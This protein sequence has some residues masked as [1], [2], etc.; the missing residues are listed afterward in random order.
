MRKAPQRRAKQGW[1]P[2]VGWM[3]EQRGGSH[4]DPF[5]RWGGVQ[6]R[7]TY[8]PLKEGTATI[9]S[10]SCFDALGS[11]WAGTWTQGC[12]RGQHHPRTTPF[13]L[14]SIYCYDLCLP[15]L[16][17]EAAAAFLFI[18]FFLLLLLLRSSHGSSCTPSCPH[19]PPLGLSLALCP[20]PSTILGFFWHSVLEF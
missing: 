3:K 7:R 1:N 8:A 5:P 19:S 20:P 10:R 4:G 14:P 15:P 11:A 6:H 17:S 12:L 16:L 2:D 18:F 13:P 9:P